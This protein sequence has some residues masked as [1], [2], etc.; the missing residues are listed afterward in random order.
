MLSVLVLIVL[1]ELE[2]HDINYILYCDDGLMYSEKNLDFMAIA[3]EILDRNEIGALF[4]KA[5]S[6]W[7]RQDGTWVGKLTFVGL[8]YDP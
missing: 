8:E 4:A 2:E 7:I 1:D 6:K 5:K 3:Q